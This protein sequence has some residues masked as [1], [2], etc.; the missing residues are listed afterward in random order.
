MMLDPT[1][2]N[3]NTGSFGPLPRCV[4]ERATQLRQR[5]AE[6]PMDFLVRAAPPLLWEAR[7]RLAGFLGG[8]PRRLVFTAN[9]TASVNL[10]ASSLCLSSPG[11]VLLSDHEYGAMQWCWERA[12]RRS[13]LTLRTFALPGMPRHPGE[14]VEAACAAMSPR[15]RLLFFSHVLSPTGMVLPARELCAEARR[16]GILT[17]VDGAHAPVFVPLDVAEVDADFY[18]GNCHKWLLAPTGAGFLYLGRGSEDRLGPLQV[19]WGWHGGGRGPDERDEF[20]ATP[21]LRRLEFEGTRDVCPWLAVPSAIDFQAALGFGAVR[22]RMRELAGHARRRLTG[23]AGLTPATPEHPELHGAMTAFRLPDGVDA[24]GLRRRLWEGYRVE[25]PVVERPD[26]LL[27]RASTHFYNTEDEI[28]R[29]A[30]ALAALL[31]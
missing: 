29:L 17:M 16:R 18:G 3:L 15:T 26:R 30:E 6:E 28:D 23:L 11:E 12:A 1:V 7:A 14:V 31:G 5:L 2:A 21:R 25:A 8:D 22:A 9:V 24:E 4:F 10:V 27:V 13:C 19:S 20:G